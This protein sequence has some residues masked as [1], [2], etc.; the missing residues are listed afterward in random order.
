MRVMALILH[1]IH[2]KSFDGDTQR[3]L[4]DTAIAILEAP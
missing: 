3:L 4:G 1:I 2:R